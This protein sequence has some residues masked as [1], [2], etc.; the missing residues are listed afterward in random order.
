MT[1]SGHWLMLGKRGIRPLFLSHEQE[2]ATVVASL[3]MSGMLGGDHHRKP[4]LRLAGRPTCLLAWASPGAVG[5]APGINGR[6]IKTLT[7]LVPLEI[8]LC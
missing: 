6:E 4:W 2:V 5:R 8:V 3:L 7:F 1:Q